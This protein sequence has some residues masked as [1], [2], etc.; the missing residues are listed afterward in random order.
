[1]PE[2]RRHARRAG[3]EQW[4]RESEYD[5]HHTAVRFAGERNTFS[6]LLHKALEAQSGMAVRT[7]QRCR[8][9]ESIRALWTQALADGEIAGAFWAVMSHAHATPDLLED[10]S[11]DVHMLSHQV[12]ASS[13]A[14]LRLLRELEREAHEVRELL[15]RQRRSFESRLAE[16][17]QETA[18]LERR[19]ACTAE[20]ERELQA[21]RARLE[22]LQDVHRLTRDLS[23]ATSIAQ[24]AGEQAAARAREA[25]EWRARCSAVERDLQR[26]RRERDAA[27][28]E[29]QRVLADA[30]VRTCN[31]ECVDLAGRRVLCVGGRTGSVEHYRALV[32]RWRG[33]F[34]HHD[35]GL[36]QSANQL[37]S[38]LCSADAVICAAGNVSHGAYYVVKRFCKQN[39]KPC[40]ML[41]GSGLAAF[42]SGLQTLATHGGAQRGVLRASAEMR[43]SA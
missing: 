9:P 25:E 16:R 20:L 23:A 2:L 24:R 34:V 32:E 5:L 43:Q 17:A 19:A 6:E 42:L 15:E 29:L 31:R 22:E 28:G 1:M 40:V 21:A 7:F 37:Q 3:I 14:D 36:E 8:T 39:G 11:H 12:G 33:G 4:N 30:C 18:T 26:M 27:E 41:K 10:A 38:L 35:G 13:R